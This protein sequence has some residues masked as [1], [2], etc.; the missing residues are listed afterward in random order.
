M[1]LD[2]LKPRDVFMFVVMLAIGV[3][4][5]FIA[6]KFALTLFHFMQAI[7]NR[8]I[9]SQ[10]EFAIL[11][12]CIFWGVFLGFM[13][14]FQLAVYLVKRTLSRQSTEGK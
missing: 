2:T 5:I 4:S 10:G 9:F 12:V 7:P 6:Q 14:T 13:R 1:K 8:N 3:A 11:F